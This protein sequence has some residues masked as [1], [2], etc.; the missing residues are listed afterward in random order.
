[1]SEDWH[2]HFQMLLGNYR[3]SPYTFLTRLKNETFKTDA[4]TFIRQINL[5]Q[6]MKKPPLP[7]RRLAEGGIFSIV[8]NYENYIDNVIDYLRMIGHNLHLYLW[9]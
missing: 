7:R 4:E 6:N 9:N 5:G 3:P 8:S 1:M 2:N